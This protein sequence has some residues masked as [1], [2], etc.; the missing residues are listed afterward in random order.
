MGIVAEE[1]PVLVRW[2]KRLL[3][4]CLLVAWLPVAVG[5]GVVKKHELRPDLF[6]WTIGREA[7]N[8]VGG[9]VVLF[10]VGS[11]PCEENC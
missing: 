5:V 8:V 7:V 4:V 11:I 10:E 3:W 2:Q 9:R 1:R 6:Y